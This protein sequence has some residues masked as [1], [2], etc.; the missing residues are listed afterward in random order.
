[1]YS[2]RCRWDFL[3]GTT[4]DRLVQ[5]NNGLTAILHIV[6]KE[7]LRQ[8]AVATGNQKHPVVSNGS[9]SPFLYSLAARAKAPAPGPACRYRRERRRLDR[10]RTA[11]RTKF[12][13]QHPSLPSYQSRWAGPSARVPAPECSGGTEGTAHRRYRRYFPSF[14]NSFSVY[15][16]MLVKLRLK[17]DTC[18][19]LVRYA[20]RVI[21]SSP[22]SNRS[23]ASRSLSSRK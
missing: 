5:N 19:Y 15:P 23:F 4:P 9:S 7:S 13:F 11:H 12:Y 22:F 17:L 20:I 6:G 14:P 1:M 2:K 18:W 16:K 3:S 8:G 21:E 10:D